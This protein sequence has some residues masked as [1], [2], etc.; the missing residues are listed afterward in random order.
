MTLVGRR[1]RARPAARGRASALLAAAA[2]GACGGSSPLLHPAHVEPQ[3]V[4]VAGAGLSGQIALG[5]AEGA[6]LD[7]QAASV[8]GAAPGDPRTYRRGAIA[9]ASYAPGVAPWVGARVGLGGQNEAGLTYSGRSMR[10]DARHAFGDERWALSVGA[11]GHG[12]LRQRDDEPSL[13]NLDLNEVSGYGFDLPVIGGW[14]SDAGLVRAWGGVRLGYERLRGR[15]GLGEPDP[16]TISA[17]RAW[18]G[19][20]VGL[21]MGFRHVYVALEVDAA[22]HRAEGR[23][24]GERGLSIEG[25][26]LAPGGAVLGRF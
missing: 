13:R 6:V 24:G 16:V 5:P 10:V 2:L 3:G 11:G 15:V 21:A 12:V 23:L 9:L 17:G 1:R 4:V 8:E 25:V 26:T 19:G 14:Q 18:G 22:Y 7:A 20:L